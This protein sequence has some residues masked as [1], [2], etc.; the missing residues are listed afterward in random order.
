MINYTSEQIN[1]VN[2]LKNNKNL[3]INAVAGSG[4][5][6]TIKLIINTLHQ[7]KTIVLLFN[8][9]LADDTKRKLYSDHVIINT[10]HSVFKL[11]YGVDCFTNNGLNEII[12]K[13]IEPCYN[14]DIDLLVIDEAQDL[15]SIHHKAII[16]L[17]NDINNPKLKIIFLGQDIQC[18]YDYMGA[19]AD[20][21]LNAD[22]LYKLFINN[23]W[24]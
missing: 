9:L 16:K 11:I 18:I 24:E 12:E 17:I 14:L 7:H 15:S 3:I 22:I 23:D 19:S 10:I 1:I 21:F 20:Y 6:T 8:R 4:K 2:N 5:T 13:R